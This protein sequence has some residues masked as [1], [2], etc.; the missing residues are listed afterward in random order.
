MQKISSYLYPNRIELLADL[1]GFTTEYTNV[2]QR[3]VKI[4]NGIDNTIEFDIKNADQ[5]RL[6]LNTSPVITGIEFNLM[7]ASGHAL[8]NSPYT[9]TPH[10]TLKGIATVTIPQEDLV[11]L[12]NQYLTYSVSALKNGADVLLYADS[13]FGAVGKIEL[14][15][16]AMPT[17][18]NERTYTSFTAEIDLNGVPTYHSSVIPCKFY[19]AVPVSTLSFD[20]TVSGFVGSIWIEATKQSTITHES[21]KEGMFVPVNTYYSNEPSGIDETIPTI[22]ANIGSYNYFRVSYTTPTINGVGSSF[23]VTPNPDTNTY[24]VTLRSGGTGYAVGSQIKVFGDQLGG[25]RGMN[26]LVITVTEIGSSSSGILNSYQLGQVQS[27]TW[28]GAIGISAPRNAY[29][30]SGKNITGTVDSVVVS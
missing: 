8:P 3:N 24:E 28:T 30:V 15:G 20:I 23:S 5:K 12:D 21:F 10:A 18:R 1:A 27:F 22:T 13:R 25:I 11:D 16:N 17:F 14:V 7:D 19:E 2:Y 26:D 4:Y 9:V 29:I 6:E